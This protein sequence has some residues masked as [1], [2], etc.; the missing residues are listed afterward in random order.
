MTTTVFYLDGI[1]SPSTLKKFAFKGRS[2]VLPPASAGNLTGEAEFS[3]ANYAASLSDDASFVEYTDSGA[4]YAGIRISFQL[5]N[6]DP[7]LASSITVNVRAVANNGY[8]GGGWNLYIKNL[9][10]NSWE[11]L[12]TYFVD[13]LTTLSGTKNSSLTNYINNQGQVQA[14]ALGNNPMDGNGSGAYIKL[15][16]AN[17]S[18][19]Y[20]DTPFPTVTPQ[21]I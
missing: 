17:I 20:T 12:A 13:A 3:D 18:C 8:S 21:I 11:S 10:T 19:D 5:N 14:L 16:F 7:S 2:G 9:G 4:D 1:T 6:V 15:S